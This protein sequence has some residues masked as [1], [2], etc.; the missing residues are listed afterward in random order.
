MPVISPDTVSNNRKIAYGQHTTVA[1]ADTVV[2]GLAVVEAV[3]VS[4]DAD[5]VDD[6]FMASAVVPASGGSFTLKTWK[7]TGGTDPT[8][9]AATTF[10]KKVNWV[11]FGY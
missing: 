1:A 2:S 10:A 6:P 3:V 4:M 8:P 5:P 9:V 11:A 7:N